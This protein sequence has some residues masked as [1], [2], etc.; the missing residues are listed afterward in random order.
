MVVDYRVNVVAIKIY[1]LSPMQIPSAAMHPFES[2][3]GQQRK[4]LQFWNF[5]V[6][7][8]TFEGDF[9]FYFHWQKKLEIKISALKSG[10]KIIEVK[11]I[12]I[13]LYI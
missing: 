4:F 12:L 7:Y 8:S 1:R 5:A 3:L 9:F 2:I 11:N 6:K 13:Y 10:L